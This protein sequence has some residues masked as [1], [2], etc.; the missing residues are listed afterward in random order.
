MSIFYG[1]GCDFFFFV[2]LAFV[3]TEQS[4][5]WEQ[6]EIWEPICGFVDMMFS[7]LLFAASTTYIIIV[8]MK[9]HVPRNLIFSPSRESDIHCTNFICTFC[10]FV[11]SFSFIIYFSFYN[12]CEIDVHVDMYRYL[13]PEILPL[14]FN[15]EC[16]ASNWGYGVSDEI[17]AWILLEFHEKPTD[18][19]NGKICW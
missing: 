14:F 8:G 4:M 10:Y 2:W 16:W 15:T 5:R 6:I 19:T 9:I 3:K 11:F 1:V 18:I 17:I 13:K 12:Y 7:R